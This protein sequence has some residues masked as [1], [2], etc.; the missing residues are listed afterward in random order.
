MKFNTTDIL[1][2]CLCTVCV[3]VT[4]TIFKSEDFHSLL[5]KKK[6]VQ[7]F[8]VLPPPQRMDDLGLCSLWSFSLEWSSGNNSP[9]YSNP[10]HFWDA[11][12]NHPHQSDSILLGTPVRALNCSWIVIS[13][14]KRRPMPSISLYSPISLNPPAPSTVP[15]TQRLAL[16]IPLLLG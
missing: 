8:K 9:V 14:M 4:Y 16:S 13:Q 3:S 5:K 10:P 7:P 6:K 15:C 2:I 12:A 11:L 1:Y